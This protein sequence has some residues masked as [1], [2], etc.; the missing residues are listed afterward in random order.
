MTINS[1]TLKTFTKNSLALSSFNDGIMI[2]EFPKVKSK[3]VIHFI[4]KEDIIK[5]MYR[6]NNFLIKESIVTSNEDILS[7]LENIS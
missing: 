2:F 5:L 6:E 3:Y 7:F 1:N 4:P